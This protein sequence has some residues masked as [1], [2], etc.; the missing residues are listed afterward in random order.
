MKKF[1]WRILAG[2]KGGLNRARIIDEL[3]NRPYNANQLAERLSLN[4]KTIK[5][6]IEVLEEND[7]VVST[8]KGY[9]TL[10]FLSDKMEENF[11]TFLKIR[12]EFRE[13]DNNICHVEDT[14]PVKI[15][16]Y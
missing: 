14:A 5:Y 8:V 12:E 2:T 15:V 10:Y 1:L 9:G 7:I 13:S 11:D 3:N 4:Y 16:N 6:H